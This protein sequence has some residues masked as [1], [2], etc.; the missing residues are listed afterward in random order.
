MPLAYQYARQFAIAGL[1]VSGALAI[2][3]ITAGLAAGSSATVADG[4]E[5]AADVLASGLLILGLTIA[6]RPA[7]HNHPYGHG[8]FEILTGLAIG[9]MLCLTGAGI[10]FH[11][12]HQIG[13]EGPPP[14]PFAI[15][16]LVI[17]LV[18]KAALSFYKLRAA[19]KIQ[20]GALAADGKND[21]VDVV[22][23]LTA[24]AALGLTLFDPVRFA[25]ADP[26]GGVLVGGI[27]LFLGGQVIRETSEQL[28]DTMPDDTNLE[29]LRRVAMSVEGV[30][31][32][33]KILARKTGLRW[34][35]DMHI[36]VDPQMTVHDSHIVAGK[37]KSALR[38]QLNWI[39]NVLVHV[40]PFES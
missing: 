36:H 34:H 37:V 25:N 8:R 29:E 30:R 24:L 20:S 11:S 16:A 14:Q 2:L 27:V 17:S 6:A 4:V 35:V 39:E 7:D 1:I 38:S 13:H 31:D 32:T 10:S 26:I 12:F 18:A 33:E 23:G 3:K 40:E 28:V 15:W 22:S 19:R 21:L 5:S 9:L